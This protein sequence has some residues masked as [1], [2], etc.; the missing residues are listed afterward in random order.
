MTHAGL[1]WAT[2]P[3]LLVRRELAAG[4]LVELQL[5]ACAH[6]LAAGAST[7]CGTRRARW[8]GRGRLTAR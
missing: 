5:G 6:R 3:R 8:A 1:G 2:L 7:C 4:E